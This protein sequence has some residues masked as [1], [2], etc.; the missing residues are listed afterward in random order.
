MWMGGK[1]QVVPMG[2]RPS[3]WTGVIFGTGEAQFTP[4]HVYPSNAQ[5][6]V[7][8]FR[9]QTLLQTCHLKSEVSPQFL[10]SV[11]STLAARLGNYFPKL[12][13]NFKFFLD[14]SLSSC[15]HS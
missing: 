7:L 9:D 10:S 6:R 5:N 3:G 2:R 11:L 15:V 8:G 14:V 13:Q 1:Q 4:T 12:T